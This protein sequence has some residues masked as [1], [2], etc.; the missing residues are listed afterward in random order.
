MS[1]NT[2]FYERLHKIIFPAAAE[3]IGGVVVIATKNKDS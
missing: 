3:A 1:S 2:G